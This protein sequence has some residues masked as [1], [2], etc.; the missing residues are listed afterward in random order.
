V[1]QYRYSK[2]GVISFNA[3]LLPNNQ[4]FGDAVATL[5]CPIDNNPAVVIGYMHIRH[6]RLYIPKTHSAVSAR[7]SVSLCNIK[8]TQQWDF[9][10]CADW[11]FHCGYVAKL[12]QSRRIVPAETAAA[13]MVT[14]TL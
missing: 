10:T 13:R 6:N 9:I 14:P 11:E 4:L 3:Y 12:L 7:N 8:H 2:E 5:L 1:L